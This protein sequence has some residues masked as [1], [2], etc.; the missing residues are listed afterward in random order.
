MGGFA[1]TQK[2]K[3]K[4]HAS[5]FDDEWQ[6]EDIE[7]V[8]D[9]HNITRAAFESVCVGGTLTSR[10]C[11]SRL[12]SKYPQ[13]HFPVA[14]MPTAAQPLTPSFPPGAPL[15]SLEKAYHSLPQNIQLATPRLLLSLLATATYLGLPYLLR[16][17]LA[18]VLRTVGPAT[19]VRY[20]GF[21][22]GDGIGEPEWDG[23][24]DEGARGLEKI[25]RTVSS[26]LTAHESDEW[27]SEVES[28]GASHDFHEVASPGQIPHRTST[29][30]SAS[31]EGNVKVGDTTVSRSA[32]VKSNSTAR[33][34]SGGPSLTPVDEGPTVS[35]LNATLPHFYG[36]VS[37]KVGEACVC[38]LSRWG[39]DVLNV[40]TSQPKSLPGEDEMPPVWGYGGIPP[41]FVSAV[42][43]SDA[44]FVPNERGRYH[45]AR[46]VFN[47][48]RDGYS[49]EDVEDDGEYDPWEDEEREIA[50][51]FANGIYY[52]HMNFEDL[53]TIS[54]DID[55][56]TALP[57]APLPVLQAAY[58][59]AADLKTR[60][61]SGKAINSARDG[62][63]DLAKT[64]SEICSLY[65]RRRNGRGRGSQSPP[66][67]PG[68]A[69]TFSALSQVSSPFASSPTT[70]LFHPIP[71]DETHRI[72]AGGML[73]LNH[74]APTET[75]PSI[76][77]MPDLGP[78]WGTPVGEPKR[79]KSDPPTHGEGTS[80]GLQR[81][82]R[83]GP[84]I[85]ARFRE[86]GGVIIPLPGMDSGKLE[87]W[88][89]TEPFR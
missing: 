42:L 33:P 55:P 40:E 52:S 25:A 77:G 84:D 75:L 60:I 79:S 18:I 14:L 46:R 45:M 27:I 59:S 49:N 68:S 81:G 4:G 85:D 17:V 39:M 76:L 41:K 54:S 69:L 50:K 87:R 38:W 74:V 88:S 26:G 34:T 53:S 35:P 15:P 12:Y 86:E 24:D 63:L 32:S 31:D 11:L 66:I 5:H 78:E 61:T 73:F 30:S 37:D 8:F 47:L 21:A 10:I 57:Y 20:L 1:E 65:A 56:D 83:L 23:Q 64:T 29:D 44:L 43:S 3:G 58:W 48:R 6:G 72:G 80:F 82:A 7:L 51:V 16:E 22:I 36:F 2:A 70:G 71:D 62:E 67:G 9:D 19:V 28:D 13:F 89:K